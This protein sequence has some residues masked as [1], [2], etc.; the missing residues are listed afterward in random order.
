MTGLS[1]EQL[2]VLGSG[3]DH[4]EG[5]ALGSDGLLYAGGEA[6]QIYRLD[7]SGGHEQIADTGGS[8]LG[9]CL[10]GAGAVYA[11]DPGNRAVM[12]LDPRSGALDR[13][14]EGAAGAPL[15]VPNGAA[16]TPDGALWVSDSGTERLDAADGRLLRVPPGGGDAEVIQIG[17]LHFPNGL[18]VGAD[19][20]VCWVESF[21]PRLRRLTDAGPEL[22]AD[23]PGVVPDGVALDADGGY[24]IACYYPFRLL[25]V[26]PASEVALL[27][28]DAHGI[29]IPM[30]TNV[31]YFGEGL[32]R[33][34]VACLG[35]YE[36][37][38]LPAPV[39]GAPLI[40]P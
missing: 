9:V 1:L 4:P 31:A 10:D 15:T 28:D 8:L 22:I 21:T 39:P 2:G 13:W 27:L 12:R 19:G 3:L 23:L 17:P 36:V 25:R 33:M 7:L 20:R 38:E 26:S 6:G 11:C 24:T 30:P 37:K 18:C 14:C 40:Y 35:G 5:V 34:A 29:H 32:T 16:F